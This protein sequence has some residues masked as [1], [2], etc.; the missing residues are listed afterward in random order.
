MK[1]DKEFL[2]FMNHSETP[3]E[4]LK[5]NILSEITSDLKHFKLHTISKFVF[6]QALSALVTLSVCPQFG[7]GFIKGHGIGHYFY[8]L[9]EWACALLCGLI[10]MGISVSLS[11]LLLQRGEKYLVSRFKFSI[12]IAS[13]SIWMGVLMLTGSLFDLEPI[14]S[15]AEYNSIWWLSAVLSSLIFLKFLAKKD[16]GVLKV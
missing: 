4:A 16:K 2:E 15:T 12:I 5:E 6:L 1:I 10:F 11:Y 14:S 3:N 9:G 7:V 13:T 8:S